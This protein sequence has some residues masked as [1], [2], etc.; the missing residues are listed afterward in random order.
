MTY[1]LISDYQ[2]GS[3]NERRAYA[4][5]IESLHISRDTVDSALG[6]IKTRA[7]FSNDCRTDW[8]IVRVVGSLPQV[9]E[10]VMHGKLAL[11][12]CDF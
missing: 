5:R 12:Y 8:A 4:G 11:I 2:K 3:R 7:A 6:R 10:E 9:G 1:A